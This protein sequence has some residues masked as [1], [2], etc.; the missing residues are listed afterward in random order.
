MASCC[1]LTHWAY[2]FLLPD[3]GWPIWALTICAVR[4]LYSMQ[5]N[6]TA[7]NNPKAPHRRQ[8]LLSSVNDG[9]VSFVWCSHPC[10]CSIQMPISHP[11]P[12]HNTDEWGHWY[13]WRWQQF[14]NRASCSSPPNHCRFVR[15]PK[16]HFSASPNW[17]TGPSW[18]QGPQSMAT[19]VAHSSLVW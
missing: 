16:G 10:L 18:C 1:S 2:H 19:C 11:K 3:T 8:F 4:Q 13:C 14:W 5:I 12:W 6:P 17:W 9:G 15:G 7:L